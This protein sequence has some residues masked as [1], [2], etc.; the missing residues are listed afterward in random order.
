M[1]SNN[2]PEGTKTGHKQILGC[3]AFNTIVP[4]AMTMHGILHPV[5]LIP[6]LATQV[7][8]F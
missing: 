7:R 3:T 4:I 1:T 6:F 2:D 8:A 5:V